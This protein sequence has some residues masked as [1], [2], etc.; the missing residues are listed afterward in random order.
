MRVNEPWR[1]AKMYS[2][3]WSGVGIVVIGNYYSSK[4]L[5]MH[6]PN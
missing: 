6:V 3:A 1:E 2:P 4:V 5:R